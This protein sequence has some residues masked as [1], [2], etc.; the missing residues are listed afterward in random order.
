MNVFCIEDFITEVHDL[1]KH[2]PYRGI[3]KEI[4]DAIFF[5]S[6]EELKSGTL[7]NNDNDRCYIKKRICGSAGYR[8]YYYLLVVS[9]NIYLP[10]NLP[11]PL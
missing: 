9:E 6:L 10:F 2:K 4:I 7:L 3:Q 5:K 8:I 1:Q 11:E